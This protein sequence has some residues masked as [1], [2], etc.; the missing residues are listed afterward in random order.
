MSLAD[1]KPCLCPLH[2]THPDLCVTSRWQAMSV[3]CV[4]VLSTPPH[5]DLCVTSRWQAMSVLC[6]CVLSIPPHTDLCVTCRWQTMCYMCL[7]PLCR[8]HRQSWCDKYHWRGVISTIFSLCVCVICRSCNAPCAHT[9]R[10]D[11]ALYKWPLL[12]LDSLPIKNSQRQA[13]CRELQL[14]NFILQWL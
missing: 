1:D 12:L 9:G 13:N 8:G 14:E 4:C 6:V 2:T 3:L 10:T 5:T 11:T 7:C